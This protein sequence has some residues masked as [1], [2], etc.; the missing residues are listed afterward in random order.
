MVSVY[1]PRKWSTRAKWTSVLKYDVTKILF[2]DISDHILY[3]GGVDLEVT[4][5]TPG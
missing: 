4:W 3:A 1:D 2:S 5:M